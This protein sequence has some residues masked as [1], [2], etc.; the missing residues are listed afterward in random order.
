MIIGNWPDGFYIGGTHPATTSDWW[1]KSIGDYTVRSVENIGWVI[2]GQQ[3]VKKDERVEFSQENSTWK[4]HIAIV[5]NTGHVRVYRGVLQESSGDNIM[6]WAEYEDRNF[7]S[8]PDRPDFKDARY[9][10]SI[11]NKNYE[12]FMVGKNKR[13]EVAMRILH[14]IGDDEHAAV[15]LSKK[16]ECKI[17]KLPLTSKV[18]EVKA[19]I[20]SHDG[21]SALVV[22]RTGYV[23]IDNPFI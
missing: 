23:I 17:L 19:T 11:G 3:C 20:F 16:G 14:S 8:H 1:H 9:Y 15:I 21:L 18:N 5:R 22:T 2:R 12:I 13:L 6:S 7:T 10:D 4:Q